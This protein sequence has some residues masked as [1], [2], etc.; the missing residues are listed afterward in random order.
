MNIL[1][2]HNFER[3][4]SKNYSSKS[5]RT[6]TFSVQSVPEDLSAIIFTSWA[7]W[8][9]LWHRIFQRW[10]NFFAAKA[11]RRLKQ[12]LDPALVSHFCCSVANKWKKLLT[13]DFCI[14]AAFLNPDATRKTFFWSTTI[15]SW[16]I[17]SSLRDSCLCRVMVMQL[18]DRGRE[19]TSFILLRNKHSNWCL[20][21]KEIS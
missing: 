21:L 12:R 16:R 11:D 2:N 3:V 20:Q 19:F 8:T 7:W 13:P 5:Y 6:T 1:V 9:K 17:F 18:T 14:F 4:D 15:F 10:A